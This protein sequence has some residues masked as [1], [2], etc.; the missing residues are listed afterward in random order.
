MNDGED[1]ASTGVLLLLDGPM[2]SWGTQSRF[3][4]RD[5]DFEPSKSGVLGLVGAALGMRRDDG[6][7]LERLRRLS[8]A[9]RVD[10]EGTVLRD[11]HTAGGG[12]FRGKPHHVYGAGTV[13]TQRFY[14]A[15]A[16]FVVA[17]SGAEPDLVSRI[18]D[19]LQC[20]KWPLFLGRRSCVPTRP[21]YLAG[22][23]TGDADSLIRSVPWQ[24]GPN[25][26]EMPESLRCVVEA[27]SGKPRADIPT[28]F[29]LYARSFDSRFV[30]DEWLNSSDLPGVQ[31]AALS[32]SIES[33]LQ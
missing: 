31:D 24:G 9:V 28:S 12:T 23:K 19:C 3:G 1:S 29:A 27:D 2:Q 11:Y 15:G 18:A 17:L 32:P 22:P 21:V 4:H 16:C 6:E 5:T 8:M 14:L 25:G 30:R 26:G 33:S 13:V 10:R 20:P 7:M